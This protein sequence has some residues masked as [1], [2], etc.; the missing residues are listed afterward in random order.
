M[1]FSTGFSLHV[2][3]ACMC[4]RSCE[5]GRYAPSKSLT[6]CLTCPAN[7]VAS[8]TGWLLFIQ[9]CVF[10]FFSSTLFFLLWPTPS[11][12]CF[13]KLFLTISKTKILFTCTFFCFIS[14]PIFLPPI[15][16]L[17]FDSY[18]ARCH[19]MSNMSW[20]LDFRSFRRG[21]SLCSWLF[22][23][24]FVVVLWTFVELGF[25]MFWIM[26]KWMNEILFC[27]SRNDSCLILSFFHYLFHCFVELLF[28]LNCFEWCMWDRFH[29]PVNKW[30]LCS[31]SLHGCFVFMFFCFIAFCCFVLCCM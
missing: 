25:L 10:P 9:L 19:I 2:W 30:M 27:S 5:L 13:L 29:F 7:F 17:C 23:T 24:R 16:F 28:L 22:R 20:T 3:N 12:I 8:H 6:A 14:F 11:L 21:V 26:H 1:D 18:F 15:S 31:S 4:S